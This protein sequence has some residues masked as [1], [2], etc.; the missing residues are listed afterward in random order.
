MSQII[1]QSINTFLPV[2][3]MSSNAVLAM[4][5]GEGNPRTFLQKGFGG[6]IW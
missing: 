4:L 3:E 6:N 1:E 2:L 5:F